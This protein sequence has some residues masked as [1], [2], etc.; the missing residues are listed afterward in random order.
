M[1]EQAEKSKKQQEFHQRFQRGKSKRREG[2][3]SVEERERPASVPPPGS[4]LPDRS[5][6]KFCASI[7]RA[8]G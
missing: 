3:I 4:V 8:V 2:D 5:A 6:K 7:A 1:L